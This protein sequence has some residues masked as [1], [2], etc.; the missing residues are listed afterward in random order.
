[1]WQ[2]HRR[3]QGQ[4]AHTFQ[5][6]ISTCPHPSGGSTARKLVFTRPSET[7]R[8]YCQL[9]TLGISCSNRFISIPQ[10]RPDTMWFCL[11]MEFTLCY[12][13]GCSFSPFWA[14]QTKSHRTRD[15]GKSELKVAVLPTFTYTESSTAAFLGD[16]RMKLCLSLFMSRKDSDCN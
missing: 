16:S 10:K 15:E 12:F 1:M 9:L 6:V 3:N 11:Y 14:L 13:T 4:S 7:A 8:C 5:P 2:G